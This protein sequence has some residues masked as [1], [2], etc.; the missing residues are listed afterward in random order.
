MP[1]E[2]HF[3]RINAGMDNIIPLTSETINIWM[4]NLEM[5][6]FWDTSLLLAVS[7]RWR[8][9][10]PTDVI[11]TNTWFWDGCGWCDKEEVCGERDYG[12]GLM[13]VWWAETVPKNETANVW[14][15]VGWVTHYPLPTIISDNYPITSHAKLRMAERGITH[16]SRENGIIE[17]EI[18]E[19]YSDDMLCPSVLLLS[20]VNNIPL[21]IVI[22]LCTNN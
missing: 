22:V 1:S 9:I 5:F 18:I 12:R 11:L 10:Y 17:G 19:K 13:A 20:M 14:V 7:R 16:T 6:L 8:N 2:L 21:H 3:F 4:R 15:V